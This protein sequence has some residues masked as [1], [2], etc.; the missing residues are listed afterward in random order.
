MRGDQLIKDQAFTI[1][2]KNKIR[3]KRLIPSGLA[4]LTSFRW[5]N[6]AETRGFSAGKRIS[7][8]ISDEFI[9]LSGFHSDFEVTNSSPLRPSTTTFLSSTKSPPSTASLCFCSNTT[10]LGSTAPKSD[11]LLFTSYSNAG[12]H[13]GDD[14]T[15]HYNIQKR[16]PAPGSHR[17]GLC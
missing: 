12:R 14:D 4:L 16:R 3:Q 15:V 2:S 5:P 10:T 7:T 9:L 11:L 17:N 1:I 6:L 8:G 13:D